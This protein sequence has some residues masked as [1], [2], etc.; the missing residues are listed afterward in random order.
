VPRMVE[1][2]HRWIGCDI[3]VSGLTTCRQRVWQQGPT[4]AVCHDIAVQ[5]GSK[6]SGGFN[7]LDLATAR[8]L[9][10]PLQPVAPA[11]GTSAHIDDPKSSL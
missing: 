10:E 4:R 2:T 8:R 6:A 1:L 3:R 11:G 7:G 9:S 5:V